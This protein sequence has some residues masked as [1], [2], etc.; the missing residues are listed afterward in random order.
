[1]SLPN[2]QCSVVNC[3]WLAR[4]RGS[5]PE[6]YVSPPDTPYTG[7][8]HPGAHPVNHQ[9]LAVPSWQL[10]EEED[11]RRACSEELLLCSV[12]LV[13]SQSVTCPWA[14]TD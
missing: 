10:G 5:V 7:T 3:P 11:G 12:P 6:T 8:G 9:P 14:S 1:M 2:Q 4:E 13:L